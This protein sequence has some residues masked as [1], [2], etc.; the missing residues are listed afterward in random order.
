M[1]REHG[2]NEMEHLRDLHTLEN[3][4]VARDRTQW[5]GGFKL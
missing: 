2:V 1:D 5:G 3:P 4:C